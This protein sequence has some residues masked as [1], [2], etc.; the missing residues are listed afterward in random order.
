MR[1]VSNNLDISTVTSEM[2]MGSFTI[3]CN[4]N[5]DN[6]VKKSSFKSRGMNEWCILKIVIKA[7]EKNAS[8]YPV[9]MLIYFE[10]V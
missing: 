4:M 5:I 7:K 3:I 6:Y 8:L 2:F 1:E 10:E 9:L